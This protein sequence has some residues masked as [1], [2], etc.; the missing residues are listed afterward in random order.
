Q[1]EVLVVRVHTL[2]SCDLPPELLHG[3]LELVALGDFS[4][5]NESAEV[6]SLDH[7][8][9][10]LQF[11]V[12]T[13]AAEGRVSGGLS[14]FVGYG[15]RRDQ[16]GLDV[17]L[18]PKLSSCVM[19]RP[20]GAEGY[21]GRHGGQAFGYANGAGVVLAAGGNDPLVSDAIVGALSFDATNGRLASLDTSS[22]GV[23]R[24]PRA[25]ATATEFGNELVVAGGETPVFGVPETD[26]EPLAN[27]EVF[28]PGLGQFTGEQI[29][30]Q[31]TRTHHAAVTLADGRTL[32]VGGRSKIGGTSIAQYQL[33]TLDP[34]SRR[35]VIGD[36]IAARIDPRALRLSDDR[37]FVGG[38]VGVDGAL[39]Q[40]VAEWLKADGRRDQTKLSLEV[41]PRFE[42]AFVA[43]AGGGVLAV[44]GC[45]DRPAISDEDAK[46]C[47]LVCG[48]G[49]P[50]TDAYDAWWIDRDGAA[51]QV[52]FEGISAPRPLLLPGSDGSPWL[53]AASSSAPEIPRLFR[54]NPW[55][56]SDQGGRMTTGSF[57][58]VPLGDDVRLPKPGLPQPLALEPDTFVWIDDAS[59]HGELVG[60]RLG[61]R[62]RYT[63]DLALV[64]LSDP[65][66]PTRPQH[67]VP[68][69]PLGD[70]A[71]YDGAL[72]LNG[73]ATV[74]IA[75]TDYQDV[76]VD[77]HLRADVPPLVL[78][79][80][81]ELGGASCPWPTGTA[82]GGAFDLASVS[83]RGRRAEL[84]FH[85]EKVAC[86]VEAGRL[87]L[88]VKSGAVSSTITQLDVKRGT[89][90]N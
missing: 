89:I 18:W 25:F 69:R 40:P 68:E 21:P 8:G 88:G 73:D 78:L 32:L 55:T 84:R 52:A 76:T 27:G 86:E 22:D 29:T 77:I 10:Q 20:D 63:Q 46:S 14:A 24:Q 79:G 56:A 81:T 26:I 38:G 44:G 15:E 65:L 45:E 85:G 83:R 2:A 37:I 64:L 5:S 7:A 43:L 47:A 11:P 70:G 30:L 19:W 62:N 3:N 59:Q 50:P 31:N 23:L 72:T 75:D 67:L 60:L 57:V 16:G 61:T 33:E 54:F 42:R 41:A 66:D 6:L 36:T 35:A 9:A 17:L 48:H 49:C 39:T 87:S 53:V 1:A 12:A 71:G 58:P 34:H 28:A 74:R 90:G 4:A 80:A 82:T 13:R 51:T